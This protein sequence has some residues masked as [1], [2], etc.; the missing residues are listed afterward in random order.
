MNITVKSLGVVSGDENGFVKFVLLEDDVLVFGKCIWHR[1]LV[2]A[3][4][5]KEVDV[6]VIAA[7]V[8]PKDV[9]KAPLD[10]SYWGEWKSSG[11]DVVTPPQYREVIKIA[12]QSFETEINR[13][14]GKV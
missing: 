8:L 4:Y 7:G 1:E 5:G 9:S 6:T 10:E 13:L 2:I 11:Y 3:F 12:L 14:W